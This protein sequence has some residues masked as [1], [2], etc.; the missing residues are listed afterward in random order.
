MNANKSGLSFLKEQTM[1]QDWIDER[2]AKVNK[3][4]ITIALFGAITAG[5]LMGLLGPFTTKLTVDLLSGLVTAVIVFK[6][7]YLFSFSFLDKDL[8]SE[9][10]NRNKF[11]IS[12]EEQPIIEKN[13]FFDIKYTYLPWNIHHHH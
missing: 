9:A 13:E 6:I 1:E 3:K 8:I 7:I 5:A 4:A 10:K 11:L 12:D 2:I